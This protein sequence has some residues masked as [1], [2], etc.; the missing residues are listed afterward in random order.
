MARPVVTAISNRVGRRFLRLH[1]HYAEAKALHRTA[2]GA[3]GFALE[4]L[5][6][7]SQIVA[8]GELNRSANVRA[9]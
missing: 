1:E 4:F 8:V 3:W 7:I 5:A 2:M 9:A 6:F